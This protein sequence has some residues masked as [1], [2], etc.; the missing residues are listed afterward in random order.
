MGY[1]YWICAT[2]NSFHDQS[3]KSKFRFIRDLSD[4]KLS[5]PMCVSFGY[6][7]INSIKNRFSRIPRLI[8]NN[9][10]IFVIAETKLDSSFPES[11]FILPGMRNPFQLDVTSRKGVSLVFVNDNI[12]SKYLRTLH[13]PGD[14]STCYSFWD[15][16]KTAQA[17]FSFY[18]STSKSKLRLDFLSSITGLLNHYLKSYKDFAIMG[19]FNTNESNA[20]MET[21]L[22]QHKCKNMNKNK[23]CYKSKEGSWTGLI[24][25]IIHSLHYSFQV[26][27]TWISDHHL[28]V[29]IMLKSTY[30]KLGPKTLRKRS[31]EDFDKESFI[32]DL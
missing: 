3:E 24:I 27:E 22:N 9:L 15:K 21:F 20:A 10:D 5:H 32:Q 13:L 30:A 29:Y 25:T 4:N 18:I 8:D 26:F 12:P 28:I 1:F 31:Y 23:T 14:I 6:L 2:G 7:N 11:Q 16:H 17:T 19:D